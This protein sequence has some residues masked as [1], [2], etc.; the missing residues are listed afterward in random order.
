MKTTVLAAAFLAALAMPAFAEDAVRTD[1]AAN[2]TRVDPIRT[3]ATTAR[4]SD[5][6]DMAVRK[7]GCMHRKTALQMM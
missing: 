7:S 5:A 6:K 3:D 2:M 1:D 4:Q